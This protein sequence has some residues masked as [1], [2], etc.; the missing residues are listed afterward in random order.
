MFDTDLGRK[1][2]N[3]DDFRTQADYYGA[4]K[5][6]QMSDM[7]THHPTMYTGSARK[8]KEHGKIGMASGKKYKEYIMTELINDLRVFLDHHYVIQK[9]TT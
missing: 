2:I 6:V 4:A 7:V 3:D 8:A 5:L 9:P 1:G